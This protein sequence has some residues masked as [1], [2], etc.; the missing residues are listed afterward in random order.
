MPGA[1][2]K[3]SDE[4]LGITTGAHVLPVVLKAVA[5]PGATRRHEGSAGRQVVERAGVHMVDIKI[6]LV[7]RHAM[8]TARETA[9]V[10]TG[11]A[12]VGPEL[13][14]Q[15]EVADSARPVQPRVFFQSL[16]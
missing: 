9:V 7:S 10:H 6:G 13:K 3:V 16:R 15:G 12:R 14:R 8:F 5:S 1:R 4:R 11:V 2:L